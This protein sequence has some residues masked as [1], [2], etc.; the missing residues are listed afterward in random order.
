MPAI[1]NAADEIFLERLRK[2]D[3]IVEQAK[4][5][6]G[7]VDALQ[8]RN[9]L[10]FHSGLLGTDADFTQDPDKVHAGFELMMRSRDKGISS[11]QLK[12]IAEQLLPTINLN[13]Y[14]ERSLAKSL[15]D[16]TPTH[17]VPELD[18][19][20][21][22]V[23]QMH[24]VDEMRNQYQDIYALMGIQPN[25]KTLS[26]H[27]L[28]HALQSIPMNFLT[29]PGKVIEDLGGDTINAIVTR[30]LLSELHARTGASDAEMADFV[31]EALH[32]HTPNPAFPHLGKH[33]K[34]FPDLYAFGNSLGEWVNS[35]DVSLSA[36]YQDNLAERLGHRPSLTERYLDYC[37][38]GYLYYVIENQ[39]D[40]EPNLPGNEISG[41]KNSQKLQRPPERSN[42][43]RG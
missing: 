10:A 4:D 6:I 3:S 37:S 30:N 26:D 15:T 25:K 35:L 8:V 1:E 42:D 18:H 14:E 23:T 11:Y 24:Q 41:P 39:L 27:A 33:H 28:S 21:H 19:L 38:D 12:L 16:Y 22:I 5:T 32:Q 34:L 7:P 29:F 20:L 43:G 36:A 9:T 13:D 2:A 40:T 17:G 31:F